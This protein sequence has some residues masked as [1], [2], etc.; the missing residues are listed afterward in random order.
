ME[1][2]T[3][4]WLDSR[5]GNFFGGNMADSAKKVIQQALDKLPDDT[6][7]EEAMERLLFLSK[8]DQGIA[9]AEAGKT[10]SSEEVRK[11]LGL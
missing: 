11:R 5:Y 9:E 3:R 10:L 8:I 7:V 4:I 1:L 6:T 2:S